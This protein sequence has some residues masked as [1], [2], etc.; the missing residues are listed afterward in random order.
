[1]PSKWN[2][3]CIS[4]RHPNFK[5]GIHFPLSAKINSVTEKWLLEFLWPVY[6]SNIRISVLNSYLSSL[7]LNSSG[8]FVLNFRIQFNFPYWKKYIFIII[9][10]R[11]TSYLF[12]NQSL[13]TEKCISWPLFKTETWSWFNRKNNFSNLFWQRLSAF[14]CF[15][16]W[17]SALKNRFFSQQFV[18]LHWK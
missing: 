13:P 14:K 9:F 3:S 12:P 11:R 15:L 18:S 4:K 6:S 17:S 8:H 2:I 10:L 5:F 16:S 7:G 1:M